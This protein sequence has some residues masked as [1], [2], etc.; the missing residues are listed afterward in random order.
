MKKLIL[1]LFI[2]LVFTCSSDNPGDSNQSENENLDNYPKLISTTR[3]HPNLCDGI[4]SN[5][6]YSYSGDK[7]ISTST[8]VYYDYIN[9]SGE[10]CIYY[11][12]EGYINNIVNNVYS[13]D[14]LV[15]QN[16]IFYNSDGVQNGNRLI[17]YEY[18]DNGLLSKMTRQGF[19]NDG[20]LNLLDE[21]IYFWTNNN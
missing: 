11:G 4:Y 10:E 13:G 17:L 9:S 2:P 16:V 21:V 19:D 20:N 12:D 15:S 1:L 18:D 7:I 3:E 6:Q 14:V 5:I 8:T